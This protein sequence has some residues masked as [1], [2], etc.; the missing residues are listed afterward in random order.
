MA[1]YRLPFPSEGPASSWYVAN[2]NWDQTPGHGVPQ[3]V[4]TDGQAYAA[5]I[6]HAIGG[7]ILAARAG[8]VLDLGNNVPDHTN[9]PGGGAGNWIWIR[10]GDG[11][12]GVYLH[13]KKDSLRVA[14]GQYVPQGFWI[15]SSGDTGNTIPQP[16]PHLH[17]EVHTYGV[18]GDKLNYPDLGTALLVHFESV[19]SA[20]FRLAPGNSLGLLSNN[21]EGDYRQDHWRYCLKCHGL[22]FAGNPGS[23]CPAGP[24]GHITE[25]GN[26]TLSVNALSPVGQTNWRYCK[27]CKGLFFGASKG[28]CPA[29]PAGHD[30]TGSGNYALPVNDPTGVGQNGW[31]WC[32]NCGGMFFQASGSTCPKSG[33]AH[34]ESGSGDYRIHAT[35]DDWQRDWRA[36]DKCRSLFF[37]PRIGQSKCPGNNNGHHVIAAG[38]AR[39]YFLPLDSSDAPGQHGWRWCDKCQILW[40]GLNSGS[41]C[42]A[43]GSHS[44][45]FSGEY[46]VI[47]NRET[48]GPGEKGWR[49]C[50]KCQGLWYDKT[51]SACPAGGAH[52]TS[53]S[54][55]YRV[56]FDGH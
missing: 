52:S 11:T 55:A 51:P 4:A 5:D 46:A 23:V 42:P 20:S 43:G 9:P 45:A 16:T 54:G 12:I 47:L 32:K 17:F 49:W 8:V 27:N 44:K 56:Q 13:L 26:Y 1:V 10:H 21:V 22:Y 53:G 7:K 34:S 29:N 2:G 14:K 50:H 35:E 48:D 15:A 30:A 18:S 3:G 36:C 6:L 33:G 39:D 40:M 38:S 41:V 25:G 28:V 37:A 31:R 24:G 19:G